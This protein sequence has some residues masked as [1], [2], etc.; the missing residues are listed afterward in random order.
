MT[1]LDALNVDDSQIIWRYFDFPKLVHLLET[2]SL[3]FSR[4]D[5][6][7]DPFEGSVTTADLSALVQGWVSMSEESGTPAGYYELEHRHRNSDPRHSLFVSCWHM[8]DFESVA[9]WRLY[10]GDMKG[11]ALKSTVGKL[12]TQLPS[13]GRIRR[14]KYIDY[15]VD[16]TSHLSPA[17]CKRNAFEY[18]REVRAVISRSS[19]PSLTGVSIKLNLDSIVD[20]IRLS[21]ELPP[22]MSDLLHQLLARYCVKAPCLP[23]LL[24]KQPQFDWEL[25]A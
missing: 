24:D 3:F 17:Y 18:E 21:P 13:E 4:L 15:A 2:S 6:L 14:V 1:S 19:N 10:A 9:M 12:R 23:S 7:G 20:E 22:W 11:I 5:L 8:S 16:K 25:E